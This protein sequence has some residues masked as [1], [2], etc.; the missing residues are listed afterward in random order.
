MS[1]VKKMEEGKHYLIRNNDQFDEPAMK[2]EQLRTDGKLAQNGA[3]VK[4]LPAVGLSEFKCEKETPEA[5]FIERTD[6]DQ[7]GVAKTLFF[8]VDKKIFHE[9]HTIYS[10]AKNKAFNHKTG[11]VK[12]EEPPRGQVIEMKPNP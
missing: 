4:P 6:F 11:D 5:Y 8:W 2:A 3:K 7:A 12:Q 10:L 9:R 1:T